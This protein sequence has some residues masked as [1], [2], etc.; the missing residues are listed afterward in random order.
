M[1]S[2]EKVMDFINAVHLRKELWD[3]EDSTFRDRVAKKDSWQA[4]D[5]EFGIKGDEASKKFK[6]LRTY[7]QNERKKPK[8]GSGASKKKPWFAF[9]A[10]QF[11]L[12]PGVAPIFSSNK[13]AGD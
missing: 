10:V 5:E 11:V 4:V 8:S 2:N 13:I 12:L 7:A 3:V 9:E 1:W 6:N